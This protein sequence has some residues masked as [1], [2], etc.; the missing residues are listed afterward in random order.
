LFQIDK[1]SSV[2]AIAAWRMRA[3][4]TTAP[5]GEVFKQIEIAMSVAT[6]QMFEVVKEV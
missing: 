4:M 1:L 6:F 5:L 2:K 3:F